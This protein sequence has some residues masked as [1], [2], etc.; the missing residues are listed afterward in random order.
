MNTVAPVTRALIVAAASISFIG[1]R[2]L[3]SP[4][5]QYGSGNYPAANPAA[6]RTITIRGEISPTLEL[7]LSA[8]Y[9]GKVSADCWTSAPYSAG[10]FEGSARP[11]QVTIPL[12]LA[13]SG[14]Q[15]T[16][17]FVV[18]RFLPGR[19]GWHFAL[20]L[21][22]VHKG[23]ATSGPTVF[24]QSFESGRSMETKVINSSRDPVTL[25]CRMLTTSSPSCLPPFGTKSS[26]WLTDTSQTVEANIVDSEEQ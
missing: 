13:R 5:Q 2:H 4:E 20:V 6:S 26:Q 14:E 1:C 9:V 21:A 7:S 8:R 19:C 15:Y 11:L 3:G 18:D 25:R 23:K 24:I 22:E 16:S 17:S 12:P 10:G